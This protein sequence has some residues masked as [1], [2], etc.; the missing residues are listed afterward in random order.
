MY[1]PKIQTTTQFY[2]H[3]TNNKN[4][5]ISEN[6]FQVDKE[7][8]LLTTNESSLID[9][10][11][12]LDF[13]NDEKETE[14]NDID[15]TP[16][17]AQ[18]TINYLKTT[19]DNEEN[20][21]RIEIA[22]TYSN[23][24]PVKFIYLAIDKNLPQNQS[25]NITHCKVKTELET[26]LELETE[27][28]TLNVDSTLEINNLNNFDTISCDEKKVN[29]K[30][31]QLED[32][33]RCS[34]D[35]N[36][37]KIVNK[38]CKNIKMIE[39]ADETKS[40]TEITTEPSNKFNKK[41][42][43]CDINFNDKKIYVMYKNL[44][45]KYFD[46]SSS[47]ECK[48]KICIKKD[49]IECDKIQSSNRKRRYKDTTQ[50]DEKLLKTVI[51]IIGEQMKKE[52]GSSVSTKKSNLKKN[53]TQ[54]NIISNKIN[55]KICKNFSSD[56]ITILTENREPRI[57][58]KPVKA[59][60]KYV[61]TSI[62][63][64]SKTLK[65]T[66]NKLL[67]SEQH[68]SF[69]PVTNMKQI[70][71]TNKQ[72]VDTKH[73]IPPLDNLNFNKNNDSIL[74]KQKNIIESLNDNIQ[75]PEFKKKNR[76][77]HRCIKS[78]L[79]QA[80]H[81]IQNVNINSKPVYTTN[82]KIETDNYC[83]S[84]SIYTSQNDEKFDPV[85]YEKSKYYQQ[86][87]EYNQNAG[88]SNIST[89]AKYDQSDN[90]NSNINQSNNAC[91]ISLLNST[92]NS[93]ECRNGN[94]FSE[95][96]SINYRKSY[97]PNWSQNYYDNNSNL[98]LSNPQN[99]YQVNNEYIYTGSST[100]KY[101]NNQSN[102]VQNCVEA[103]MSNIQNSQNFAYPQ[104]EY[105]QNHYTQNYVNQTNI[106]NHHNSNHYI[107]DKQKSKIKTVIANSSPSQHQIPYKD[108]YVDVYE[109]K[110]CG[111]SFKKIKSRNAHMKIHKNQDK[112]S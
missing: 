12:S 70:E 38:I 82:A 100:Q 102:S 96:N 84:D 90:H 39:K 86:Y 35:K 6:S 68:I 110:V 77:N 36:D 62:I 94:Q 89:P 72:I 80:N 97:N 109:C 54:K 3:C 18:A 10:N 48:K 31:Q 63:S 73:N 13:E 61:N 53:V 19:N 59:V 51:E 92:L 93:N 78:H 81:P 52:L 105:E 107:S 87:G 60:H 101:P 74:S 85:E 9:L 16:M 76:N 23:G 83:T 37:M 7:S 44:N 25:I 17:Q 26:E 75:K 64:N 11:E 21:K 69:I 50:N 32:S 108:N 103:E 91:V 28:S 65:L 14:I 112:K 58:I 33:E 98:N 34:Q 24:I 79:S 95:F 57:N 22:E 106:Y 27:N 8:S 5:D 67:Q 104:N 40:K 46:K 66:K 29:D 2:E 43:K 1:E 20:I 45:V 41:Q 111:K 71:W 47:Q 4:I 49:R 55:H 99:L 30:I 88:V 15:S 56:N 42:E